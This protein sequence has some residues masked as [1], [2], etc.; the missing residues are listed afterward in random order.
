MEIVK[1]SQE[2]ISGLYHMKSMNAQGKA[3]ETDGSPAIGGENLGMRPM[4]LLLAALGSCST[5]DI[6][7]I[8]KKQR[9]Q[10]EDLKV[11]ITAEKEKIEDH[12]EFRNIHLDFQFYGQVKPEKAKRAIDLSLD[13][14]CSVAM[15]LKKTS[16]ITYD[17]KILEGTP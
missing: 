12:S 5:I 14:Y 17:F 6:V 16:T 7:L 15:T 2:R 9:Q 1:I 10:L 13:K 8:L 11:E 4:E 3:I